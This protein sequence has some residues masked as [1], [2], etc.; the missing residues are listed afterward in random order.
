MCTESLGLSNPGGI[1]CQESA[2]QQPTDSSPRY[3]R[4]LQPAIGT[5]PGRTIK[6]GSKLWL[7]GQITAKAL[8]AGPNAARAMRYWTLEIILCTLPCAL[9]FTNGQRPSG[10]SWSR[11]CSRQWTCS[12]QHSHQKKARHRYPPSPRALQPRPR[13]AAQTTRFLLQ[14]AC[15]D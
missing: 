11:P 7:V 12:A 14:L 1:T 3:R 4:P 15:N 8:T 2:T 10:C 13:P 5:S 6:H 9:A